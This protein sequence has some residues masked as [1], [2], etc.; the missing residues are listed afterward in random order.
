LKEYFY[1]D[2]AKIGLVLGK[3]FVHPTAEKLRLAAF[4]EELED[5][6]EDKQEYVFSSPE[7]WNAEAFASIYE[8]PQD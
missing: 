3:A 6:Y 4:D 7:E 5:R 8:D 1:N 2:P